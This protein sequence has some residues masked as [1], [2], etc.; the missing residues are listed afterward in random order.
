MKILSK[1]DT[2]KILDFLKKNYEIFKATNKKLK[3]YTRDWKYVNFTNS[4]IKFLKKLTDQV[5]T[6]DLK[7]LYRG[8]SL[9]KELNKD[10]NKDF[11]LKNLPGRKFSSW[12]TKSED[13]NYFSSGSYNS[14][15]F[16]AKYKKNFFIKI[17]NYMSIV[18]SITSWV[19]YGD[20]YDK[21]SNKII[22][23]LTEFNLY[24][25][26]EVWLFGPVKCKI[27]KY[28]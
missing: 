21:L 27:Y 16:K 12:T 11:I 20:D 24:D 2:I 13:A 17:Y 23:I 22:D 15:I 28:T 8:I 10:K 3:K 9:K 6:P 4:E 18:N 7:F 14:Y 5:K 26:E 19:D 1:K 25:E